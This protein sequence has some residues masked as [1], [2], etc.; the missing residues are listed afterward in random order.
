M[1]TSMVSCWLARLVL[2]CQS[3]GQS[4]AKVLNQ[5]RPATIGVKL[6]GFYHSLSDTLLHHTVYYI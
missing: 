5:E 4:M 2:F 6:R 3:A 1:I